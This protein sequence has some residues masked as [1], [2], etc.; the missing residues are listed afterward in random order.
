MLHAWHFTVQ[1][2][3]IVVMFSAGDHIKASPYAKKLA[4]EAGISLAGIAGTGPEGRIVAA[5]VQQAVAS[6]KVRADAVLLLLSHPAT[7]TELHALL[8]AWP[9]A[10]MQ[11]HSLL[12]QQH[13]GFSTRM[14]ESPSHTLP[15]VWPA[16][17]HRPPQLAPH[18][19]HPQPLL[20][21]PL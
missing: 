17:S 5:D 19:P 15:T 1:H 7:C 18:P 13:V 9:S 16:C 8:C 2:G 11:L 21:L 12:Q 14:L 4:A 20:P 10:G 6:G 3:H